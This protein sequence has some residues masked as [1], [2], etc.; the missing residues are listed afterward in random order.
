ME[1][2]EG[3]GFDLKNLPWEGYG[4]FLEQHIQF[5]YFPAT[6]ARFV[7]EDILKHNVFKLP[8][9]LLYAFQKR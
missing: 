7:Q 5:S 2:P 4:Y 3:G 6:A 1:F 8:L 9:G